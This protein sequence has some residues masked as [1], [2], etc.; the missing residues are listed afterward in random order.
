MFIDY[1]ETLPKLQRAV[2]AKAIQ[3]TQSRNKKPT[4]KQNNS[5]D[6]VQFKEYPI[7]VE[8]TVSE[9]EIDDLQQIELKN[10]A[11][12]RTVQS[13]KNLKYITNNHTD[14]TLLHPK[15]SKSE[16]IT[17]DSLMNANREKLVSDTKEKKREIN[18]IFSPNKH[19]IIAPIGFIDPDALI[20]D[21]VCYNY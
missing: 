13:C 5:L 7:M 4:I 16:Y 11:K 18:H 1:P 15:K 14:H 9:V 3:H 12:P 19:K 20:S 21:E 8:R 2:S 6:Y 17:T 10:V